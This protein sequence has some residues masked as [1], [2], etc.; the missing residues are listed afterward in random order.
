MR[1]DINN[2]PEWLTCTCYRCAAIRISVAGTHLVSVCNKCGELLVGKKE[3]L[4]TR[5]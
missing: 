2:P 1:I 5:L 4:P 3:G